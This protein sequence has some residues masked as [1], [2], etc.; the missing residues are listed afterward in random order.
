MKKQKKIA[1]KK[2]SN[3][4][5]RK[6]TPRRKQ[7]STKIPQTI[8]SVIKGLEPIIVHETSDKESDDIINNVDDEWKGSVKSL[9]VYVKKKSEELVNDNKEK[10]NKIL[11]NDDEKKRNVAPVGTAW[12][13]KIISDM[14]DYPKANKVASRVQRLIQFNAITTYESYL[15]N[16]DKRKKEPTYPD[17]INLGAVDKAMAVLSHASDTPLL[18]LR[19][20][21]WDRDLK[22]VFLLPEYVFRKHIKKFNLPTIRLVD[23]DIVFDFSVEEYTKVRR[24]KTCYE[25]RHRS[26]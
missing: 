25:G 8:V 14:S 3:K 7:K 20:K 4:K 16:T 21:C 23:D 24:H 13:H 17:Q 26:I 19:F 22:F 18:V 10:L 2:A 9:I 6:K 11:I 1:P 5:K 15:K 12:R